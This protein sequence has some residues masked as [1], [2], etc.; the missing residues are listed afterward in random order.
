MDLDYSA[1]Y[2]FMMPLTQ[3]WTRKFELAQKEKKPFTE[4][5]EQCQSFFAGA[6][7]FMWNDNYRLRYMGA[8]VNKPKFQLTINKAF[9]LV[10]I[11]G[12]YL[13]W[14]YPSRR[15]TS[16]EPIE[17]LPELYGADEI[18]QFRFQQAQQRSIFRQ[19]RGNYRNKL[20]EK[21]LN[22][23][24]RE[25]PDGGMAA[26]AELAITEALI[27]GRG[28]MSVRAYKHPGS[29]TQLTG[30]FYESV[31]DLL[32][33]PDS[34]D[35]LLRDCK[36]MALKHEMPMWEVE[37]LFNFQRGTLLQRGKYESMDSMATN[38]G[39]QAQM[40]RRNGQ[41]N[42][43]IVWYEVWS[44]GGVGSRMNH[45]G[46]T[47]AGGT[48][49]F[50]ALPDDLHKAFDRA[51]GDYAYL[52]IC[53]EVPWPL[54]APSG[55]VKKLK[56]DK[57]VAK[58]FRWRAAG[59]GPEFPAWKD[60]RWP[61]V[62]LDFYKVPGSAWPVAPLAPALGELT[63]LNVLM[64][65][66]VEQGYENRKTYIAYL[67]HAKK[68]IESAVK[69]TDNPAFIEI[70]EA[71]V[72]EINKMIQFLQRPDMNKDLLVAIEYL[73]NSFDK[74]T[75]LT[76]IHYAM[77]VG[78][79]QSRSARDA[80][81]KEEKASI[82][83]EKM[84]K[85]VA[86]WMTQLAQLE[87]FLAGWVVEGYS[88]VPLLGMDGAMWWD[89]L[90]SNENPEVVVREMSAMVEASDIRRPN[91]ERLASNMQQMLQYLF[92]LYQQ[93]AQDTGD[94]SPLNGFLESFGQSIEQD[95]RP[96]KL[97]PWRPEPD[98]EMEQMQQLQMQFEQMKLEAD[99]E[100]KQLAAQKTQIEVAKAEVELQQAQVEAFQSQNQG[101]MEAQSKQL[102][103]DFDRL[104]HLQGMRQEEEVFRQKMR[105]NS[106][107]FFQ[108]LEQR[109]REARE[110]YMQMRMEGNI[111][112]DLAE[113]QADIK[114][115]AARQQAKIQTQRA[116]QQSRKPATNGSAK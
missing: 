11:F 24:Q 83:P 54:N 43:M 80:A 5:A 62:L 94:V 40:H 19:Q 41:S 7:G 63:A 69:G 48:D 60:S 35:P 106:L 25:Q 55:V 29:N 87:K 38:F 6:C 8:A 27:K 59:Y 100:G 86:L 85:D 107:E 12:P 79:V 32:I 68:N 45:V 64:S 51:V 22:Y 18:G 91:K 110:K 109:K 111:K 39:G 20:M 46:G 53:P 66:L 114:T 37:D 61:L 47:S 77:N 95:L 67:S 108:E 82:R 92:P 42:D 30:C 115:N 78:G 50:R 56:T 73:M 90:I 99:V 26:H 93:Y 14:N 74:R 101:E 57:E 21:Y 103:F 10:A 72:Q 76:E 89:E 15:I 71:G 44:K 112:L 16:P 34:K 70:S 3:Q 84:S 1:K 58:L 104:E 65:A 98:P 13:F 105:Q 23:S 88:L 28:V 17:L 49:D 113:D 31:D 4:I 9:E 81:V 116:R 97:G 75:G 36:W 96:W 33:D 52:C 102:Q 2:E